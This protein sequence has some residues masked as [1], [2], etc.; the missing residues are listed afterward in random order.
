[1]EKKGGSRLNI[2]IIHPDLGIGNDNVG[3]PFFFFS[4]LVNELMGWF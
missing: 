4:V 2:A 3:K 1:M